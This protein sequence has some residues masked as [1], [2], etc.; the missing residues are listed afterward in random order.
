MKTTRICRTIPLSKQPLALVLIQLRYSPILNLKE[1]IPPI[2]DRLRK[3]G[4]P[5]V[6][7]K[8]MKKLVISSSELMPMDMQQW[9]FETQDK[10]SSVIVD[11]DQA[12]LQ[13]TDYHSFE[14]FLKRYFAVLQP[15]LEITEHDIHGRAQRV[16]L[17][18]VDQVTLQSD[19]D[20]IDSY[21][22]PP[23]RGM[24]SP[25]FKN[26]HKQY[27]HIEV[28]ETELRNGQKGTLSI[29]V[30]R[31]AEGLD[32]PSDLFQE[33]PLRLRMIDVKDDFALI[34]M[35]HGCEEPFS[36]NQVGIP[37]QQLEELYF[38][39]HDTIIEVFHESVVTGE[40]VEKW[41]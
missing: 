34:D 5:L 31:N 25:F 41:K 15:I 18:Y 7:L 12:L 39:L 17:R 16:G 14:E 36:H 21:L 23:M 30:L 29:R 27:T 1:Y 9:K 40:G 6:Y 24:V 38:S 28:G 35:D 10:R 11:Q 2:Q 33:A 26:K 32:L 37:I 19:T 13:T 8:N 22:R 4:F 20:T 3:I